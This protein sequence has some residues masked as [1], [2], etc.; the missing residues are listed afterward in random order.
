MDQES[1]MTSR[2]FVNVHR[3]Q[4]L[5]VVIGA[6]GMGMAIARRLGTSHRVLLA[7]RDPD[8]LDRQIAAM[9]DEGHDA[10]GVVCDVV[11]AQSVNRLA[12]L[13]NEAGVLRALA[14]VVGLSPSMADGETILRVNT[15]GPALV[16]D[17]FQRI[18]R[19][20][21][22]AVFIASLAAHMRRFTDVEARVFDQPL[23]A[24]FVGSVTAVL[25]GEIDSRTAYQLSKTALVRMC[26]QRAAAWGEHGARIMSLSPG[27]IATPMGAREFE[28]NP[29]KYDLLARVPLHR[30]GTM[31]EI[32]DAVD[33]LISDRASYITGI[34]LL[35]DG[36]ISAALSP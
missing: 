25:G 27:L 15:I 14:H 17:A 32:A 22:A 12:A 7:D 5:A 1:Q 9:R 3:Q 23:D 20:G 18:L 35:V 11:D 30:E 28:A 4:P 26:R 29:E 31:L 19:P 33:F 6:G 24:T 16:A 10:T 21:M 34:D 8:H 13:A 36:G 2:A